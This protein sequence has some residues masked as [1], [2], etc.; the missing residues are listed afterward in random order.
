MF[1]IALPLLLVFLV[2]VGS[3]AQSPR[4]FLGKLDATLSPDLVHVYQRVYSPVKDISTYKLDP[5]PEP[6]TRFVTGDFIDYRISGGK[7]Q[8]L[9]GEPKA[10][11]PFV[12]IDANRNGIFAPGERA[13][14]NATSRTPSYAGILVLPID[15]SRYKGY[16]IYFGYFADFHHPQIPEDS[17]LIAQS[18]YVLAYGHAN[19]L[20][21]DV[22]LQYPFDTDK[23]SISTTE[24]LFG[25]DVDGD[26]SIRDQQF[27]VE[28]QSV[29]DEEAIFPVGGIYVST[30]TI[31]MATG[32]IHLRERNKTDYTRIDLEVGQVMPN[33]DFVDFDGKQRKLSDFR[34]KYVMVDFWGAWCGDCTRETPY[35]LSAYE[36][37]RKRGFE[38]L[39]VD[40]DD[41]IDTAKAYIFQNK[42]TWTQATND[43]TKDL[44]HKR[45]KLQEYPST[46]LLGPDGKILVL[47]QDRL[48]GDALLE[49][50][51]KFLPH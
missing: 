17:R 34:G 15:N 4:E 26:K 32:V 8:I 33:F 50:L 20:G 18:V 2:A 16:P 41:K 40:S 45:Y 22:L 10:G 25:L 38:I 51:E 7:T 36:K 44:Q 19:I 42:I 24:G 30:S 47:D 11:A 12:W 48:H 35:H 6:G 49:T 31:D 14:L 39:G 23:P 43:S 37:F 9:V 21:R 1:R 27:S 28:S 29:D 13:P 3:S 5:K 46:I